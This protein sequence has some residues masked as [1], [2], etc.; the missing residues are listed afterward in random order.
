[1]ADDAVVMIARIIEGS[2]WHALVDDEVVGRGH[3]LRRPDGRVF[4]SI[5]VWQD[6][7][8]HCLVD[9]M[10]ADLPGTV[11]T[12]VDDDDHESQTRWRASGFV[13]C[14]Q[15]REYL[16]PTDP[17]VTGLDSVTPPPGVTI[18]PLGQADET[19]LVELD[20]VVRAEVTATVGWQT[21]PVEMVT[22]PDGTPGVVDPSMYVVAEQEECYVGLARIALVPRRARLGLVAV[23]TAQRRRG[24]ARAMLAELL[25]TL[26]RRGITSV[27]AEV[28]DSNA[29]AQ[30][31]L[32]GIGARQVGGAMELLH[33]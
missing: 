5:D 20:R 24:L 19:P 9:T 16:I 6:A 11:Y 18:L 13:V 12:V 8:F 2:R 31:L 22:R 4:L 21:M 25:G 7:V 14:R 32:A 27:S 33:R 30:A 28:D 10:L 1:V 29:P 15:E 3:A 23:R 17:A 26:H